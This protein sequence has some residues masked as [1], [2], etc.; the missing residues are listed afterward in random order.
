MSANS[1]GDW[2]RI[3]NNKN[4][5]MANQSA[6]RWAG[7]TSNSCV[8]PGYSLWFPTHSE[9]VP[10][11]DAAFYYLA[12]NT[13]GD[14]EIVRIAVR[15]ELIAQA[16]T[17]GTDFSNRTRWCQQNP[18]GPVI[19]EDPAFGLSVWL[20]KL[21]FAYDYI[22]PS[23]TPGERST[24][25][26][27]FLNAGTYFVQN[28]DKWLTAARFPGRNSDNYSNPTNQGVGGEIKRTHFDGWQ[29]DGWIQTWSNRAATIIRF[30]TL[31][32][33]MLNDTY[34]K[35]QGKRYFKESIKYGTF[36]DGTIVEYY[37]WENSHPD[38]GW[39]YASIFLGSLASMADAFARTG[40]LELYNFSTSEGHNGTAGGPKNLSQMITLHLSMVNGTIVRYGTE[41]AA[42]NGNSNHRINTEDPISG[43]RYVDDTDFAQANVFYRSAFNKSIYLR[44]ASGAPAYPPG[45]GQTGPWNPW[46][47]EWGVYPGVLFMFGQMDGNVWPYPTGASQPL[48][49]NLNAQPETVAPGQSTTLTWS[50]SNATSCSASG[51][52][53][54]S[55]ATSGT[56][57]VT[58]TQTATYTLTCTN[59]SGSSTQSTVVTVF[60]PNQTNTT[61]I[62]AGGDSFTA[63]RHHIR[64]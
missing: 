16:A 30:G 62:K 6:G 47:G 43:E 42:N 63:G 53:T 34:L 44:E 37:R 4:T 18:Y 46:T 57:T 38:L 49:I 32:G 40:D 19:D 3:V 24:L 23:L 58:P 10:I 56:Q 61:A 7:Q 14:R 13:A 33:V 29:T 15:N 64:S 35:N 39:A 28:L 5:F 59:P 25:D 41:T 17:P 22:R 1:P 2:T 50:T 51:G 60:T 11:R 45:G 55:K 20:T 26:T 36:P 54:G 52:W 12:N 9:S 8:Q 27:W 21:L 31:V 48:T